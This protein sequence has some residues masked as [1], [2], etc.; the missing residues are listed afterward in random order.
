MLYQGASLAQ[1]TD[2]M[3]HAEMM[4]PEL[5]GLDSTGLGGTGLVSGAG[6]CAV[7]RSGN[8]ALPYNTEGMY[9]GWISSQG[10][11]VAIHET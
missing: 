4:D 10:V 7:D 1:A 2:A 5:T 8:V 3:V 6:L 11:Y 9:R